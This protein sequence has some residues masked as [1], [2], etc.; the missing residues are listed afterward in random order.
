MAQTEFMNRNELRK[1]R[2]VYKIARG[3]MVSTSAVEVILGRIKRLSQKHRTMAT[4]DCD[5]YGVVR[6]QVYCVGRIDDYA[7]AKH[8]ASVKSAYTIP[9]DEE[10]IFDREMERINEKLITLG[11][12]LGLYMEFQD[13]PRGETVKV[14]YK[15]VEVCLN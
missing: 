9:G 11:N 13:D 15:S 4:A 12:R 6:G 10:T 1:A 3:Q 14:F 2:D 8:G 7:K 5:G